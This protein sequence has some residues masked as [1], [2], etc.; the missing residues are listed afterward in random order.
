[1]IYAV[2]PFTLELSKTLSQISIPVTTGD[3]KRRFLISLTNGGKPYKLSDGCRAAFT[4]TKSDG[5]ILYNDCVI[6]DNTVVQYDFTEQTTSAAGRIDCQIKLYGE[7][8]EILAAP[9]FT[10]VVYKKAADIENNV[11]ENEKTVIENMIAREA[12]RIVA[13]EARQKSFAEMI[14]S[15]GDLGGISVSDTMPTNPRIVAWV[16]SDAEDDEVYLLTKEDLAK[17]RGTLTDVQLIASRWEG[18]LSPYSQVIAIDGVTENSMVDILWN[19]N[20]YEEFRN[21]DIAFVAENEGGVVTVYAI[22][23]KLLNDYTVQAL[24][25][26]VNL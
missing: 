6:L 2:Y 3:T 16:D 20:Q 11:S 22:G 19:K 15:F 13:E 12:G 21:K 25:T 17:T 7:N 24:I 26:E 9:R 23:Q 1:M 18:D 10:M 8:G 4:G 5:R 14:E